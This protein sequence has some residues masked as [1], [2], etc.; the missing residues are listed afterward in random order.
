MTGILYARLVVAGAAL[1][2]GGCLG[3]DGVQNGMIFSAA[4]SNSSL[5]G[6]AAT[7]TSHRLVVAKTRVDTQDPTGRSVALCAEAPADTATAASSALAASLSGKAGTIN[8]IA[9]PQVAASV[10]S[11]YAQTIS[12]LVVRSQGLAMYRDGMYALCQAHMNGALSSAQY[13]QAADALRVSS[14]QVM[15]A[16]LKLGM[17]GKLPPVK[18]DV[19]PAPPSLPKIEG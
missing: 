9:D 3:N 15:L 18:A 11:A 1:S 7:D 14:V 8:G 5:V 10:A 13:A 12:S 17:L 16:E 6:Y 2:V 19:P 4:G